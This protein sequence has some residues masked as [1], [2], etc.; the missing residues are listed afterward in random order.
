MEVVGGCLISL[1]ESF[2]F[3]FPGV[4]VA[5]GGDGNGGS[6]REEAQCLTEVDALFFHN[7]GEDIAAG[8]AGAEAVP[9]LLLGVDEEGGV[10]FAV[11]GAERPEVTACL[12]ESYMLA[13][14]LNDVCFLFYFVDNGHDYIILPINTWLLY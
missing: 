6:F 2:L 7:E 4:T 9:A 14:N 8:A 5:S 13:D 3:V 10:P 11:E 1:K 12:G